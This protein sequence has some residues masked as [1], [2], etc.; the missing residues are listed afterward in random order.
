M[1]CATEMEYTRKW[2]QSL[3][4]R[5]PN[6][7]M[8][9]SKSDSIS[10]MLGDPFEAVAAS[11][12]VAGKNEAKVVSGLLDN[13]KNVDI[14]DEGEVEAE[15]DTAGVVAAVVFR[16]RVLLSQVP[17]RSETGSL[18]PGILVE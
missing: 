6:I 2:P 9:R 16:V 11:P 12:A 4:T 14:G 8:E 7:G 1:T 10:P 15:A 3:E 13:I 17:L 5:L 18:E